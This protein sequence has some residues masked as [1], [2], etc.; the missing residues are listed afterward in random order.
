MSKIG[1]YSWIMI[2]RGP[3]RCVDES[4]QDQEDSPQDVEMASSTNVDQSHVI[5]SSMEETHASK[6]QEQPS[7]MNCFSKKVHSDRQ[8]EVECYS[9][10]R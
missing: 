8:N 3:N 2:S 6:Q 5:T 1:S 4:W 10:L 7:L 9:C